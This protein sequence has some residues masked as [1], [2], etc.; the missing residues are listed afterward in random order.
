MIFLTSKAIDRAAKAVRIQTTKFSTLTQK[1]APVTMFMLAVFAASLAGA[2][3]NS[4]NDHSPGIA[5]ISICSPTGTGT[6]M[7]VQGYCPTGTFDTQQ[8]VLGPG[9]VGSVNRN[10]ALGVGAVPDEHS[11]VFAP[12]T[13]GANNDYLFFLATPEG[14]HG[15]IGMS[16]LSGGNGPNNYG[17]WS[18]DFP[19]ADGY[20]YYGAVGFGQVFNPSSRGGICPTV[21]DETQQDQTFDMHYAAGGSVVT[22]PTSPPGSL[23]L[24]YE[25]TNSCRGNPG[26]TGQPT[27]PIFD[28]D[29]YISLGIATSVDYGKDW[30]TYRPTPPTFDRFFMPDVNPT[31]GPN[32]AI[33]AWG[34]NVC[35]GNDCITTPPAF[36][37]RYP[38]VTP[39]IPLSTFVTQGMQTGGK[40]GEGEISGFVDDVGGN[41]MPFLYVNWS[42]VNVAQAQLNGGSGLL[43][44]LKWN[45][46]QFSPTSK[47]IGGA[48]VS[49]LP[50]AGAFA[51]CEDPGQNRFGSSISYVDST[52][53]YLLTF[54]CVSKGD[55]NPQNGEP[56]TTTKGAAWFYSTSYDLTT[57]SWSAPS[58][59]QGTWNTFGPCESGPND[60]YYNG[61]YPTFVSLG[62]KP[63]HLSMTGYVFYLVGCQGGGTPG[64]RIFSSRAFTITKAVSPGQ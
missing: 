12:G 32:K 18:L 23:L 2:Q 60:P 34:S 4:G 63:G 57:Q 29:D 40:Y 36:Y 1:L 15:E 25:G 13:L 62:K 8:E 17:A 10:V 64:G 58:E 26:I 22:D 3:G 16:V 31:Q 27:G 30:P 51:N 24:V 7:Q 20:G 61:W 44:F 14:G 37:G 43:Q 19:Y 46:T 48:E 53:Q 59:I 49:V 21:A 54:V 38:V 56:V 42:H 45:G 6:G 41:K 28:N 47:G 50:S 52:Q 11:T 9:G 35:M 5:A 33:G 55:P 39:P